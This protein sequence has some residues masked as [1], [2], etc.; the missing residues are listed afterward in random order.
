VR[1]MQIGLLV[2]LTAFMRRLEMALR[3][4]WRSKPVD[5]QCGSDA[6]PSFI[7]GT[8]AATARKFA[9][10]LTNCCN[11]LALPSAR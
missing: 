8:T 5:A 6:R 10:R 7:H 4:R 11:R 2:S 1:P 3:P 9:K